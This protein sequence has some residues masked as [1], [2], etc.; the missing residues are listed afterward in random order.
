MTI[1]AK[2]IK[3]SPTT[4]RELGG[5]APHF[6]ELITVDRLGEVLKSAS[7]NVRDADLVLVGRGCSV[8]SCT[9]VAPPDVTLPQALQKFRDHNVANHF[10][11]SSNES[12]FLFG[13]RP[14]GQ[15]GNLPIREERRGKESDKT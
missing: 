8:E 10:G 1:T 12:I 5:Y 4:S 6:R 15:E 11:D 14:T 3:P 13:Q 7:P 2:K 9:W